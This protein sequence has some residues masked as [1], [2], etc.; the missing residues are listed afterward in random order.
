MKV[1]FII[2]AVSCL[3]AYA[4]G[5]QLAPSIYGVSNA[6]RDVCFNVPIEDSQLATSSSAPRPYFSCANE[7]KLRIISCENSP[8]TDQECPLN[9]IGANTV[10]Q[11]AQCN[12]PSTLVNSNCTVALQTLCNGVTDCIFRY[13]QLPQ[14]G[15]FNSQT[16]T[17]TNIVPIDSKIHVEFVCQIKRGHFRP[18]ANKRYGQKFSRNLNHPLRKLSYNRMAQL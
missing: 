8:S 1:T 3:F 11:P 17:T 14:L 9:F 6:Q 4:T 13:T 15:C 5:F 7:G 10:N 2:A 16:S 12:S 18:F